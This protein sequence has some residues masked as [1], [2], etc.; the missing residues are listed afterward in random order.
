MKFKKN[1]MVFYLPCSNPRTSTGDVIMYV[2]G[3]DKE[4]QRYK[5][6]DLGIYDDNYENISYCEEND[7][8]LVPLDSKYRK[9]DDCRN[10]INEEWFD[11]LCYPVCECTGTHREEIREAIHHYPPAPMIQEW[12]KMQ[13]L[14][15]ERQESRKFKKG[16]MVFYA[17]ESKEKND[18]KIL[19]VIEYDQIADKYKCFEPGMSGNESRVCYCFSEEMEPAPKNLKLRRNPNLANISKKKWYNELCYPLYYY[20][21]GKEVLLRKAWYTYEEFEEIVKCQKE[22]EKY[23]EREKNEQS[24]DNTKR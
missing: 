20:H 3:Y 11:E 1:D 4:R 2:M 15:N 8:G 18:R 5:C 13:K 6:F 21:D 9:D 23:I 14:N 16:E 19:Y 24:Q 7:L 22:Y 12:L 10:P 17:P